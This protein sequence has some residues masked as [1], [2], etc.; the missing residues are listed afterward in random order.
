MGEARRT[1]MSSATPSHPAAL[2]PN[3]GTIAAWA[4][5]FVYGVRATAFWSAALLPLLVI[6]ALAVGA[7]N[8][9][10]AVVAGMLTLNAVCVVVGHNHTPEK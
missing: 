7:A 5:R 2:A 3:R 1:T 8:Q 6:T 10:P 4:N 9:Y